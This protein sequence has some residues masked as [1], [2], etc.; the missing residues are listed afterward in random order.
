ML[1][2]VSLKMIDST[3][4]LCYNVSVWMVE[5]FVVTLIKSNEMK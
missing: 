3:C 1:E 4:C 2:R 5:M